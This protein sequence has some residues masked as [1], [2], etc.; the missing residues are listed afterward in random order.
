MGALP[1]D[2]DARQEWET[3]ETLYRGLDSEFHFDLD[4]AASEANAKTL[5]FISKTMDGLKTD[6]EGK[7]IWCNP[8][9]RNIA[10]WV[11]RSAELAHRTD[12][13]CALLL[14]ARTEQKWFQLVLHR[15]TELAFFDSRIQFVPPK[16]I[17]PSS[18][19][20]AHLL[21]IFSMARSRTLTIRDSRTG[22]KIHSWGLV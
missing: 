10:P 7:H 4:V 11:E 6:W 2:Q 8:P 16:G 15:A 19:R 5:H 9:Y 12:K 17:A 18:N 3:P 14:P 22:A 20:E 13:L 1:C 21:V